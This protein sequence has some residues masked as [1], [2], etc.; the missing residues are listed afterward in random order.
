MLSGKFGD[1]LRRVRRLKVALAPGQKLNPSAS[2]PAAIMAS[3]S[4][5]L[6]MPQILTN[7][8]RPYAAVANPSRRLGEIRRRHVFDQLHDSVLPFASDLLQ[9]WIILIQAHPQICHQRIELIAKQIDRRSY[10][11]IAFHG[12]VD[13][14]D[15]KLYRIAQRRLVIE[16]AIENRFAIFCFSDLQE[17]A[18]ACRVD[19]VS[20]G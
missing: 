19:A 10:R 17:R 8:G 7:T 16:S 9:I 1:P 13:G 6:V 15:S 18:V 14:N 4:A 3:A 5:G 12:R 11:N 2:A 20:C